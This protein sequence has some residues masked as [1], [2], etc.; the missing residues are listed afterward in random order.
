[1]S[2]LIKHNRIIRI[3]IVFIMMFVVCFSYTAKTVYADDN[4]LFL[5]SGTVDDPYLICSAEDLLNLSE[6]VNSGVTYYH[7]YVQLANDID[8]QGIEMQPIGLYGGGNYFW[9][10]FD[11]NGYVIRNINIRSESNAGLF[12]QL[13]GTVMN[14]GIESGTIS[15][16][17]CDGAIAS[18]AASR[19]ALIVNCYNKASIFAER[20]RA[21]GIAD[22]FDGT[23]LNCWSDC[24]LDAQQTAGIVSYSCRVINCCYST[25]QLRPG[26][27][28]CGLDSSEVI[29]E[30]LY[31]SDMAYVLNDNLSNNL[32]Y[33]L[34]SKIDVTRMNTWQYVD[35]ELG[36]S[37][38]KAEVYTNLKIRPLL[39]E[40]V[41]FVLLIAFF[42][43]FIFYFKY[44][45]DFSKPNCHKTAL[46]S[47]A[48]IISSFLSY[49]FCMI[50]FRGYS[51]NQVFFRD[52]SDTFMDFYNSVYDAANKH[53]YENRVIYPPICNLIY[54]I[55]ARFVSKRTFQDVYHFPGGS[56]IRNLQGINLAFILYNGI[57][58][59]LMFFGL[60]TIIRNRSRKTKAFVIVATIWSFAFL[61]I[62]F[63]TYNNKNK[64]LRELGL[65][66]LAIGGVIKIYPVIFGVLLLQDKRFKEAVRAVIYGILMFFVPFVFFGGK[67]A[68]LLLIDNI[69]R[70]AG[71]TG[72]ISLYI[73]NV[74]PTGIY[75]Y[76]AEFTD[77]DFSSTKWI[78]V[79]IGILLI[80][81]SFFERERW[82]KIAMIT[83]SMICIMPTVGTYVMIYMLI[84]WLLMI[85]EKEK[86]WKKSDYFYSFLF[87]ALFA[88]VP[89]GV[90]S[91][92]EYYNA[93]Y[94]VPVTQLVNTITITMFSFSLIFEFFYVRFSKKM[95]VVI[96]L[97]M[98]II[99]SVFSVYSYKKAAGEPLNSSVYIDLT[100]EDSAER[101][102]YILSGL[103][104]CIDGYTWT[105]SNNMLISYLQVI[106]G[107]DYQL[108]FNV[109]DTY[110]NKSYSQEIVLYDDNQEIYR[111]V[112]KGES[113]VV[114]PIHAE[115]DKLKLRVELPMATSPY[116]LEHVEDRRSLSMQLE[117]IEL[118]PV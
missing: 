82:K 98:A 51:S 38:Q 92:M 21:G 81:I 96:S 102:K 20:L 17:L 26:Y 88:M 45:K 29:D 87:I 10:T 33:D 67:D 109:H 24:E 110:N 80:I 56:E 74:N 61:V 118:V 64:L 34:G 117:S 15:G 97:L 99:V 95:Y 9:G 60:F 1:M 55:C 76:I 3:L 65:I 103:D 115:K 68:I 78:G 25:Q 2:S 66:S 37:R 75:S 83:C 5:G 19:S 40:I 11:G 84:P 58:F 44:K 105:V 6:S 116:T 30:F 71:K 94:I 104:E 35:G 49:I 63:A 89:L 79:I 41:F 100:V 42:S 16:G 93:S 36:F 59:I 111:C 101:S 28:S 4:T 90:I 91:R 27:A 14:L 32:Y 57:I 85:R 77:M 70:H 22:N 62:Y 50:I 108:V 8:M 53:P 7:Q 52:S 31:S 113:V 112:T 69:T 54:Y 114:I 107:R 12:G 18:H 73:Y 86:Q 106:P 43:A 13:G 48:F 39:S 47:S 46:L 23:I 72:G